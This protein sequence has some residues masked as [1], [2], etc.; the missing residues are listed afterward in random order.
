MGETSMPVP[1][2]LGNIF[3]TYESGSLAG[4]WQ[5]FCALTCHCLSRNPAWPVPDPLD[6]ARFHPENYTVTNSQVSRKAV[7]GHQSGCKDA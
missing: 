4:G 2:D 6:Y 7:P 1:M 3:A 5:I